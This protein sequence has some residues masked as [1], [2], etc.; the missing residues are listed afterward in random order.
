MLRNRWSFTLALYRES[1]APIGQ[2]PIEVDWEP[3]R[4]WVRHVALCQGASIRERGDEEVRP[5]WRRTAGPALRG[6]QVAIDTDGRPGGITCDFPSTYFGVVARALSSPL[7][8]AGHL[9]AG[10]RFRY[11]ALAYPCP[12][13]A[14][15]ARATTFAVE[16]VTPAPRL[17]EASLDSLRLQ[18]VAIGQPAAGEVPA[19]APARVLDEIAALTKQASPLE[20]GG[21]LVGHLHRD[22]GAGVVFANISAQ[23]PAR[24]TQASAV[25]LAFTSDTWHDLLQAIDTRGQGELMLGW[26]HSHPV[27]EWCR[28]NQCPEIEHDRCAAAMNLF[29]EH[30]RAVHRTVFPG[31]HAVAL[32]ANDVS[33]ADVR[34][35]VYGWSLG[36][37]LARGLHVLG[38]T[39]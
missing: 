17:S 8:E 28:Q 31:A 25:R 3:A 18:S 21:A 30:D 20:T 9:K 15:A 32:V 7:V 29:S 38:H 23:L 24:H 36:V 2:L 10:E 13:A 12:P 16:D 22:A 4:Q 19:F 5:L 34:F 14:S 26:W 35:S 37:L 11:M 6:F 27:R 39:P 1:G 33:A